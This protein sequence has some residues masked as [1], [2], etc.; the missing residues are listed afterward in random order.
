MS[1]ILSGK[2]LAFQTFEIIHQHVI[3]R[4][5]ISIESVLKNIGDSTILKY[6]PD[7]PKK[8]VTRDYLFTIVNTVDR[9]F[10]VR[11]EEELALR[12]K[13]KMESKQKDVVEINTQMY[14]LI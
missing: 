9:T 4:S 2:K 12:D 7:E 10:F 3:P 11:A 8:H 13:Q 6:L 5:E 14:E 1:Q